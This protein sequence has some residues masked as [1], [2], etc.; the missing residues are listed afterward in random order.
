MTLTIS[1][2]KDQEELYKNCDAVD[3]DK[4]VDPW[5]KS[6]EV[7]DTHHSEHAKADQWLNEHKEQ[8]QDQENHKKLLPKLAVRSTLHNVLFFVYDIAI[9]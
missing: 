8:V 4:Q 1:L 6:F 9:S 2:F 5:P 3:E 7:L